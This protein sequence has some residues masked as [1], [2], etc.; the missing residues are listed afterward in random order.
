MQW[1]IVTGRCTALENLD[2]PQ[3]AASDQT[4]PLELDRPEASQS[5]LS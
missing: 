4:D 3:L 1:N 2:L 5:P